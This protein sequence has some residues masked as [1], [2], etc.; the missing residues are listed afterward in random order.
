MALDE[1]RV[2]LRFKDSPSEDCAEVNEVLD[3]HLGHVTGRIRELRVL[4]RQLRD[5]RSQC[6]SI[7]S[8]A[9]CGILKQLDSD[10]AALVLPMQRPADLHGHGA[11]VH[12]RPTRNSR[13]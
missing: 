6:R 1:I 10:G 7:E 11:A 2:L 3:E 13:S 5:L 8:G 9:D 12:G 4:E